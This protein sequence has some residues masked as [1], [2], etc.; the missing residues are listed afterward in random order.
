MIEPPPP[1][2]ISDEHSQIDDA[3]FHFNTSPVAQ[4][5]SKVRRSPTAS[6]PELEEVAP[7]V[8]AIERSKVLAS[9]K[10]VD[11]VMRIFEEPAVITPEA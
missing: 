1:L 6:R 10:P 2:V 3:S 4:P 7:V 11:E 8:P 9:R 5:L